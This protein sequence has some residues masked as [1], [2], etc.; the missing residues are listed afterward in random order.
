MVLEQVNAKRQANLAP[1]KNSNGLARP[2]LVS[3]RPMEISARELRTCSETELLLYFLDI[4]FLIVSFTDFTFFPRE[5]REAVGDL[6]TSLYTKSSLPCETKCCKCLHHRK[7]SPETGF[8]IQTIQILGS[9]KNISILQDLGI[10]L[11]LTQFCYLSL[12]G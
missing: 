9:Q 11:M 6:I 7:G 5:M 8:E 2:T 12:F 1:F 4:L 3:D 10:F